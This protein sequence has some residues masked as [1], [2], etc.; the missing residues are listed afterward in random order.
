MTTGK[1]KG[2]LEAHI[3]ERYFDGRQALRVR[4]EDLGNG[5]W[6]AYSEPELASAIER[7]E[8]FGVVGRA[9]LRFHLIEG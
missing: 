5:R 4:V 9:K 6:M 8:F 1:T 2:E 3:R 7:R